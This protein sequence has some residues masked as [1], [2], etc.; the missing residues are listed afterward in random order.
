MRWN[1]DYE[2][3]TK[4]HVHEGDLHNNN[5]NKLFD[6][7]IKQPQLFPNS[8]EYTPNFERDLRFWTNEKWDLG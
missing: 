8:P 5:N 7:Q 1:L 4:Q 6:V 2:N 3:Y